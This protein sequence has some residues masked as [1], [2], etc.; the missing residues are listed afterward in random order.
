MPHDERGVFEFETA[1]L[2][3]PF[4]ILVSIVISLVKISALQ[5]RVHYALTQTAQTLSV[6]AYALEVTGIADHIVK[7]EEKSE[8]FKTQVNGTK[9]DI[10][11]F[12][13]ALQSLDI[14]QA[15]TKGS[16]VV[17]TAQSVKA[18]PKSAVTGL[19]MFGLSEGGSEAFGLLCR[20]IVGGFL[21]NGDM[22]GDEY[23]KSMNVVGGVDGLDF[24]EFTALSFGEA[25]EH[26]SKLINSDGDLVIVCNYEVDI[27]RNILPFPIGSIDITHN[28]KTKVWLDGRGEGYPDD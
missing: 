21:A 5:A 15:Y 23:L 11:T 3:V 14:Q 1:M 27:F 6:Y 9:D 26:A 16:S 25:G 28:I 19:L 20:P 12:L 2:F 24:H 18:D 13:S 22:D 8:A 7:A 4:V 10:D 17:Q